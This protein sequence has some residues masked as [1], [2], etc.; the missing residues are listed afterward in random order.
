MSNS[1][2][3]DDNNYIFIDGYHDKICNQI[4]SNDECEICYEKFIKLDEK[5]YDDFLNNNKKYIKNNNLSFYITDNYFWSNRFECLTCKKK[6]CKA[7]FSSFRNHRFW[8]PDEYILYEYDLEQIDEN[9]C[10]EGI[11]GEDCPI[12]CPF[13]RRKD[14]KIYY[15]HNIQYSIKFDHNYYKYNQQYKWKIPY[16]LL[17]EIK[18]NNFHLKS[19]HIQV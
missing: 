1:S 16:E 17:Y 9:Q 12:E 10:V 19:L 13:C 15:E 11:P 2:L 8:I 14:Y 7:C 3:S 6:I 4:K 18:K 5:Q